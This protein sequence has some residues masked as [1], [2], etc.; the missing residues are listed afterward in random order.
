MMMK[1]EASTFR[2]DEERIKKYSQLVQDL[3]DQPL[4]YEDL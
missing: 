2:K 1:E 4:V 3:L